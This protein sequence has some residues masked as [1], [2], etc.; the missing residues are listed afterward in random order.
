MQGNSCCDYLHFLDQIANIYWFIEKARKLQKNIYFCFIDYT[1][2]LTVW[3]T[4]NCGKILRRWEYQT[5]LP[6]SRETCMQA[7][8]QQLEPDM[9]QWTN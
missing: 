2:P 6:A 4:K 1:K 8:K 5:T 7:K 9:G 3:I